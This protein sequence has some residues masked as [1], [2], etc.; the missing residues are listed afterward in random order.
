MKKTNILLGL[1][2]LLFTASAATAQTVCCGWNPT[3]EACEGFCPAGTECT[4]T[5]FQ[6]CN[7]TPII[8]EECH[9]DGQGCSG[10][11]EVGVCTEVATGICGCSGTTTTTTEPTTTT[12]EP[13]SST[14][15]TPATTTTT[16]LFECVPEGDSYPI[17][18]GAL[19]CCP[20]LTAISCST[21][22][23]NGTCTEC[24]G[25]MICAYCGNGICGLGENI[26]NCPQ[27]CTTT[28]VPEFATSAVG[29]VILLTTPAFAYLLIRK[30]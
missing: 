13:T 24:V 1:I 14:T 6:T 2:I 16:T 17:V 11:C 18:P 15:T 26:C 23:Q 9:W 29:L 10:Y 19:S 27:D 22:D 5:G 8:I 28:N 25:A 4:E 21:P 3:A 30:R 12:T 7:C 20:G